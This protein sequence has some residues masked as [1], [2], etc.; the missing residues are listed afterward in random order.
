MKEGSYLE[1]EP[2]M[3]VVGRGGK[4]LGVVDEVLEDEGSGIFVGLVIKAGHLFGHPM[5]LHG[6]HVERL[7]DGV[8][9][10]D[11]AP[12]QLE[13][14]VRPAEV[15]RERARTEAATDGRG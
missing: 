8:V 5:L 4:S 12:E 2:G 14:Y 10:I 13:P 7:H 9:Y 15:L 3:R 11:A 1:I 6:E